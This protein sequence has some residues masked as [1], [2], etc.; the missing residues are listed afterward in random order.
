MYTRWIAH[1]MARCSLSLLARS[2]ICKLSVKGFYSAPVLGGLFRASGFTA[3]RSLV[4]EG[5]RQH[6]SALSSFFSPHIRVDI[7][8]L[9][10]V[11]RAAAV[12][13]GS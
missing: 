13:P 6:K 7:A 5:S 3:A 9:W 8:S 11:R 1:R 4:V 12:G 10:M 2:A